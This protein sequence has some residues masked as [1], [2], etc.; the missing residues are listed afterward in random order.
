MRLLFITLTNIGDV[1]LS[2]TLLRRLVNAYPQATVD[3][4]AGPG[5]LP[6]FEG[7]PNLGRLIPLVK[8]RR[9]AHYL[10]VWRQLK[11]TP[12]E[13][14]ADLRTPLL[15]CFLK[16]RHRLFFH[17]RDHL[18]RSEQFARL[19]P[20]TGRA[21]PQVWV[22]PD[23]LTQTAAEVAAFAKGRRVVALA[24]TANWIGKQWPQKNW[25]DLVARLEKKHPGQHAYVVLGAAH[26]R[27]TVADFLATLPPDRTLDRVGGASLPQAYGYIAA[28]QHFVGNDSGLAHLASAA[29]MPSLVLFGPTPDHIYAPAGA[30]LAVAPARPRRELNLEPEALPRLITDLSVASVAPLVEELL[31]C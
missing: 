19:W 20:G 18:P 2:T 7:L 27:P 6:L 31:S 1:V 22:R 24:P 16:A 26:E 5:A 4:V 15:G 29:Q 21:Q 3:I 12:Y 11:D 9:H 17:K 30:R 10:D 14:V 13:L 23:T 8:Q 28:S 25:A